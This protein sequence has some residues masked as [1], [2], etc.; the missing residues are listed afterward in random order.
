VW[1]RFNLGGKVPSGATW[2][3]LILVWST[4]SFTNYHPNPS[5]QSLSST[6]AVLLYRLRY[7]YARY[8]LVTQKATVHWNMRM[9]QSLV[10]KDFYTEFGPNASLLKTSTVLNFPL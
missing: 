3:V 7:L 5:A 8:A 1:R 9:R 4:S 6:V 10:L 2:R